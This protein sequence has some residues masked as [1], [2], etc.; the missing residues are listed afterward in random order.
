ME[1][2]QQQVHTQHGQTKRGQNQNKHSKGSVSSI[3][4]PY[5]SA[6]P[7]AA[8]P[9]PPRVHV[10]LLQGRR[11]KQISFLE[12]LEIQRQGPI[13]TWQE[14]FGTFHASRADAM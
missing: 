9:F 7:L 8:W 12:L 4:T 13:N 1:F 14:P 11:A 5:T 6:N 3:I 10:H 2:V